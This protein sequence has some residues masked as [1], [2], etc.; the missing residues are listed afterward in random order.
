MVLSGLM[1][2]L[3]H[4]F[5]Q[6]PWL[7]EYHGSLPRAWLLHSFGSLKRY[8]CSAAMVLSQGVAARPRWFSQ[9]LWLSP[10][11]ISAFPSGGEIV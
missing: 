7:L 11:L 10:P 3:S 2:A 6:S 8:G 4:W 9:N 1:A 5:S